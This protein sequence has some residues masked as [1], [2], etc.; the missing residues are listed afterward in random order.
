MRLLE[1]QS[2]DIILVEERLQ[3]FH[4]HQPSETGSHLIRT[5]KSIQAQDHILWIG[6]SAHLKCDQSSLEASGVDLC[7]GKPPP[8]MSVDLRN[9]L[10]GTIL[11]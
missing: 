1:T 5:L 4:N 11:V 6:V 2:F 10:L 3:A 8:R 7:W 9:K